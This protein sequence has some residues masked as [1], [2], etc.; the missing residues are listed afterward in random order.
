MY[1]KWWTTFNDHE[2]DSICQCYVL[3]RGE[4]VSMCVEVTMN[5]A[6]RR[7]MS[8]EGWAEGSCD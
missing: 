1:A 8:C 6:V 7:M 2:V 3:P 5:N 4:G